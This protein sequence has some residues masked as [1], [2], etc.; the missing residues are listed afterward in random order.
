MRYSMYNAEQWSKL[1]WK[2][3]HYWGTDGRSFHESL[4]NWQW[5]LWI[6]AIW[7]TR[8]RRRRWWYGTPGADRFKCLTQGLKSDS[9]LSWGLNPRPLLSH[10]CA[11]NN[12]MSPIF[13]KKQKC[14]CSSDNCEWWVRP[15]SSPLSSK[16]QLRRY[17]LKEWFSS[18]QYNSRSCVMSRWAVLAA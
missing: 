12:T 5:C 17:L 14:S 3:V 4:L 16:H 13:N 6:C 2:W 15:S 9:L 10:H 1:V 7:R 18:L 11:R 8:R